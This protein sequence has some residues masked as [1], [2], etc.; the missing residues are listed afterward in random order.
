MFKFILSL[1]C[2]AW[3]ITAVAQVQTNASFEKKELVHGSDTLRY[4]VQYPLNYKAK[5]KYPLVL[6]LHG[7]GERGSD[8]ELQLKWGGS[9]FA[10]TANRLQYPA[11]VVFPQCPQA[12]TWARMSG[13]ADVDS[14]KRF[15]FLSDEPVGVALGLVM[16]LVDS[17]VAAGVVNSKKLYVG[18]LSMGGMGTYELLWRRPGLFA[19]AFPICGAGDTSKV[20]EYAKKFPVWIFQGDRDPAVAVTYARAMVAAFTKAGAS[21][22]YTEY[23]GVGHDSWKNAFAEPA[24]LPWL[25]KQQR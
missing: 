12:D 19:A 10:D 14:T 5:Q 2:M 7:S 20:K 3:A 15:N 16:R 21:L 22:Q 9:L 24:L 6:L 1:G 18:G 25:F 4:R 23:P 11:I 13:R 17:L 8:N